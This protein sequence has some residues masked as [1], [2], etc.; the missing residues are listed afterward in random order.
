MAPMD[1]HT[2]LMTL[3]IAAGA[4]LFLRIIGKEKYRRERWLLYRQ[5]SQI[6]DQRSEAGDDPGDVV[7]VDEADPGKPS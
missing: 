3:M 7:I 5:E 6:N 4:G 1:L 2:L